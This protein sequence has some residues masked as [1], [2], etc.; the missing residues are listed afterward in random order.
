M[1]KKKLVLRKET[2]TKLDS[3]AKNQI[4]G[5][6]GED[7]ESCQSCGY[8]YTAEDEDLDNCPVCGATRSKPKSQRVGCPNSATFCD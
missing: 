3:Y 4:F 2:I 6:E 1:E 8:S 5:G 7:E